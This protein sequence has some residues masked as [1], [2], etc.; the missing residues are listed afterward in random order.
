MEHG[1]IQKN[2]YQNL[3]N[4]LNKKK[5]TIHGKGK[6]F[7]FYLSV[8]D[9]CEGVIKIIKKGKVNTIYNIASNKY[10]NV[11]QVVK[12][13]ADYLKIDFRKNITF[14]NDRPF[15]DKNYRINCNKLKKLNWK[16]KRNL[17][18]DIPKLC[19]W[20]KVNKNIFKV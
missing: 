7:R 11:K 4:F 8:E 9:F 19:Q 13:I 15:N 17:K 3:Y 12:M 1:S 6:N 16:V 14:V 20:Y 2:L 5:M 18:D 10:Y